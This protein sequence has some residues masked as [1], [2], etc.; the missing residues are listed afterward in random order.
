[1]LDAFGQIFNVLIEINS[2]RHYKLFDNVI[3]DTSKSLP[4]LTELLK[5]Y[6]KFIV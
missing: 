3:S 4:L 2:H 1:M 5:T 6:F